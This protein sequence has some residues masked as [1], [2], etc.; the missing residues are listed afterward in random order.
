MIVL[1]AGPLIAIINKGDASHDL[2][3]RAL[4]QFT[5]PMLTTWPAF[6]E[7]MYFLGDKSGWEG[8]QALWRMVQKGALKIA[9]AS[10]QMMARMPELMRKFRDIP[11]DL[12]DA[13]LVALA[14]A[15]RTNVIFTLDSDFEVYRLPPHYK[16]G[17]ELIPAK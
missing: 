6:T 13:S 11:M 14:E 8:Q 12:A 7:A 5:L 17:F 3:V 1:D 4:D 16:K 10:T 9:E 15:K 2:C